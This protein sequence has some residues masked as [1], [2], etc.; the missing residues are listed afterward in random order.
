[1]RII[2]YF[3]LLSLLFFGTLSVFVA[4]KNGKFS[5][6]QSKLISVPKQDVF[7]YVA[8]GKNFETFNP[9][10][11]KNATI[12]NFQ[13]FGKDSIIQDFIQ[14]DLNTQ[15]HLTFKDTLS[16]MTIVTW[17]TNGSVGFKDKFLAIL[18]RGTKSNLADMFENGLNSL[19][20]ILTS[21]INTYQVKLDGFMDRD[22]IF[23]IQR[24]VS[25]KT[26]ELP[27]KIKTVL[28]KLYRLL[29][30][31]NTASNGY[32]FIIYHS[33]DT[34]QN[35]ITFSI[36]IPT[37]E[38]VYTSTESDIIT[39]QTDA[40]QVVKATLTGNYNHKKEALA[41]IYEFMAKNKL[42]QSDRHKEVEIISKNITTDKSASK[43]VTE[44]LVPVRPIKSV[45]KPRTV[46]QDSTKVNSPKSRKDSIK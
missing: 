45:F 46:A 7:N 36:A 19:N 12:N 32:P 9:W 44:I 30:S 17:K 29:K 28:P 18:G 27:M 15:L 3:I 5:V 34:L 37:K 40:F 20:N 1:M 42:E 25:C 43:W 26:E 38:K 11:E 33:K 31:A 13:F 22:T 23:Y 4:T 2:K 10:K 6:K 14:G 39:G 8:D 24:P 21:E 41:K 16:K 35:R